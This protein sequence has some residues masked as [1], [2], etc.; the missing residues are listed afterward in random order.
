MRWVRTWPERIPPGRSYVV[1][2]LPRITM[3]DHDYA[4]VLGQLDGDTIIAEWD[5]AVSFEGIARFTEVC[6]ARPE[7]VHVAPYR[8]Y[9]A[10]T[11]SVEPVWAHRRVGRNPP[12]I[13]EG[14]PECDLFSFGL[15]YLP[16]LVV[17]KYLATD[18]GVS[19]DA[20]FSQWHHNAGLG[21]V[22][23]CWDV[24]PIHLHY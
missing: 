21:P 15:V 7:R 8:L 6:E 5:I 2:G 3:R 11:N 19:G 12:W 13:A 10:S 1:D 4:P 18:P 17:S 24:R 22:P 23:V 9:P 16:H 14:E 20:R